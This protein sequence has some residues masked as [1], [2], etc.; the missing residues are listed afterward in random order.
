MPG[1]RFGT[2][3]PKR[4]GEVGRRRSFSV[5]R[6]APVVHIDVFRCSHDVQ[7][8]LVLLQHCVVNIGEPLEGGLNIGFVR[9]RLRDDDNEP[10]LGE[11]FGEQGVAV[12]GFSRVAHKDQP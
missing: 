6:N 2:L 12:N 3:V 7:V 10:S 5:T 4:V 11:F 1:R 8:R 9:K